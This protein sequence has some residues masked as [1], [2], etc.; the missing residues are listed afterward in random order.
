MKIKALFVYL[1]VSHVYYCCLL[2]SFLFSL[3]LFLVKHY[4]TRII[5]DILLVDD[6]WRR[7]SEGI[8][9]GVL[10]R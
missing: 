8:H 2:F 3:H 10:L 1:V 5:L 9:I 6:P 7:A 4:T